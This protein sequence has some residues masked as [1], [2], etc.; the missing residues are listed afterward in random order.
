VREL[1]RLARG[2]LDLESRLDAAG[3]GGSGE[4][5]WPRVELLELPGRLRVVAD[6]PG[7]A[8]RS[9]R[10]ELR[11]RELHLRGQRREPRPA[12]TS[13]LLLSERRQGRFAVTLLLPR[14]VSPGRARAR[15]DGGRL[16]VEL[17][18]ARPRG[19]RVRVGEGGRT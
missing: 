1:E 3:R 6:L 10:V 5:A 8:A 13:A 19:F 15:L 11:G 14:E 7:V 2:L 18:G 9:L 16:T 4:R 17:P 12:G